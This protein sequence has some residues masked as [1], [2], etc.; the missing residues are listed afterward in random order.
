MRYYTTIYTI[1]LYTIIMTS[2]YGARLRQTETGES[3]C[4]SVLVHQ[5]PDCWA[6]YATYENFEFFASSSLSQP[7]MYHWSPSSFSTSFQLITVLNVQNVL[8]QK[9]RFL[10]TMFFGL[11]TMIT[12][13][14]QAVNYH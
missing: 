14:I 2:H 6:T 11:I 3:F 5:K 4:L 13:Y 1:L 7:A 8:N 12:F 9:K 10:C